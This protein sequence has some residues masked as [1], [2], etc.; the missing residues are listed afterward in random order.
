MSAP[1]Y[2]L[3]TRLAEAF[4]VVFSV[5]TEAQQLVA[6]NW[7]AK[8]TLPY[9]TYLTVQENTQGAFFSNGKTSAGVCNIRDAVL[10]SCGYLQYVSW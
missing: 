1:A 9:Y 7:V 5:K 6:E 4:L 2:S 8:C 10:P 3:I